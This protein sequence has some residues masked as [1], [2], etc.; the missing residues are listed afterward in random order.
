[1]MQF[2]APAGRAQTARTPT[3]VLS[4]DRDPFRPHGCLSAVNSH[5]VRLTRGIGSTSATQRISSFTSLARL[6]L[7][8]GTDATEIPGSLGWNTGTWF[9]QS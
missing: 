3:H 2:R 6:M 7:A 8:R 5:V 9:N 1:M 4:R